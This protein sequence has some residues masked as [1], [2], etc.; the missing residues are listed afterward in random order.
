MENDR[1]F[2]QDYPL[3][4]LIAA[5]HT[6][7]QQQTEQALCSLGYQPDLAADGSEVIG[8]TDNNDYDVILVDIGMAGKDSTLATR[9]AH[10]RDNMRPLIIAMGGDEQTTGV[11]QF[12]LEA[13]MDHFFSDPIDLRELRLQLKACAVLTGN[14]HTRA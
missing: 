2:S 4:I 13:G 3:N 10:L 9:L 6:K 7:S 5:S 12:C 8:K 1:S 11:R 14:C